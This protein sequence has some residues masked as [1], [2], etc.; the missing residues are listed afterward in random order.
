MATDPTQNNLLE[1]PTTV[2][3]ND[4]MAT[5]VDP[6][7]RAALEALGHKDAGWF[8]NLWSRFWASIWDGLSLL[9]TEIAN[10]LDLVLAFVGKFFVLGQGEKNSKF[11]DLSGAILEDLTGVPVD[12]AALKQ[13]AFGSGRLAGM[14]K[15]GADLYD[16]LSKEFDPKTGDLETP[17]AD[18]AKVFLG[19]LMNFAIRQGN[20]ELLTSLLPESM[21]FGEGYR[22]YG[23]LMA[24]NLGLGRMA[25]RALQPLIQTKVADPLQNLLNAQY[26]PKRLAKEM[27]IKAYFR[28]DME[29]PQLRKELAEEEFSDTRQNLLIHDAR[30]LP[31]D[32]EIIHLFFAGVLNDVDTQKELTARGLDANTQLLT[33]ESERPRL[34]KLEILRLYGFGQISRDET[35]QRLGQL[36]YTA[37]DAESLVIGYEMEIQAVHRPKNIHHKARTFQQLRKEFLDG[38]IDLTE[39]TDALTQIGYDPD[40]LSAMTQDLL[41]DQAGRKTTRTTHAIPS[42]SW[43]QLKAAYKAGVLDRQEVTDHLTHRGYSAADIAILLKEL[44]APPTTPAP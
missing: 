7:K 16:L 8:T 19:F 44:P 24:K 10:D 23:E 31:S 18:P 33:T 40:A 11:Y 9:V 30:P 1:V 12:V 43:A 37:S 36:G 5:E 39:W 21:R 29:L 27:A 14:E 2:V 26:R 22:A 15:F 4:L 34:D 6:R 41:L 28:G 32:R 42:L 38:V 35:L 25:R 20:I 13:S 17:S 3:V